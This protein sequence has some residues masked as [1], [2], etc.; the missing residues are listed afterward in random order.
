MKEKINYDNFVELDNF[1]LIDCYALLKKE[2]KRAIVN[3]GHVIT[4][5]H[6]EE[7]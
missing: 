4:F 2:G 3:D 1:T 6:D 7:E 5:I